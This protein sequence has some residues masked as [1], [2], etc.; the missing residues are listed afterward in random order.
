M[1][2]A[3]GILG[4]AL[5]VAGRRR[6]WEVHGTQHL[7]PAEG[8]ELAG[9]QL[10]S[11]AAHDLEQV[12]R[13]L[14]RVRPDAVINAIG[15][16]RSRCTDSRQA[17]L[18]NAY[19]PR[20]LAASA[21]ALDV[22]LVHVSAASVFQGGRGPYWET[23]RPDAQDPFGRTKAAGELGDPV[24]T[25]R[26]SFVG[27]DPAGAHGLLAWLARQRGLVGG[28]SNHRWSGLAAPCLAR[29][30]LD[31]AVSPEVTGLLHLHGEDT[32][33][34]RLLRLLARDAG[35]AVQVEEV[36]AERPVDRRLRSTRLG[37][38]GL[39]VPPLADQVRELASFMKEQVS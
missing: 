13:L 16:A 23:D 30:L 33:K 19:V 11:L 2:G 28:W 14:G 25:V 29:V 7:S 24:L 34:A 8:A 39:E 9:V 4:R 17:W 6:G 35:Y 18:A 10:H 15:L 37:E 5:A 3:T 36:E 31:L 22:R 21:R 38:L 12:R 1:A 20:I 26:T 32:T 27:H